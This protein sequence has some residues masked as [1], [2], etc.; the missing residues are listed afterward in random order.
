MPATVGRLTILTV[1]NSVRVGQELNSAS[2]L[3]KNA[4]KVGQQ[5]EVGQ[6]LK[7]G[8]Q[9]IIGQQLNIAC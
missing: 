7:V 8:Q 6:Q 5:L 2:L 9:L 4:G 1:M 3:A